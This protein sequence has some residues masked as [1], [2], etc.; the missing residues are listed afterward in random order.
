[1]NKILRLFSVVVLEGQIDDHEII[2]Q[3][4]I[5]EIDAVFENLQEKRVLSHKWH[6]NLITDQKH[7]LGYTSFMSPSLTDR[8][9]FNFF[10]SHISTT[11]QDFFHQ[12]N[13]EGEWNF[14]NSWVSIYPK[15]AY[16]P[17]HDHKP[18]QWSGVYYVK[19]H[20]NCGDIIF[21]DPKEYALQNEPE[22]TAYRGNFKHKITPKPGMLLLFPSYL[23]HETNPNEEDEDRIII[24]FNITTDRSNLHRCSSSKQINV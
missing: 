7:Q 17:L 24:S 6:A 4:L 14:V 23:K 3:R 10:H 11:I 20:D 16:V 18:M 21:T 12:L 22:N 13:Y 5:K 9:N 2:N 19:A 15:G 1:M 8:S